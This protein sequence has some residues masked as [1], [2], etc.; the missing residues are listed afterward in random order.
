MSVIA[1]PLDSAVL[2]AILIFF[3]GYALGR[4]SK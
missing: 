3:A 2:S 1:F 4:A